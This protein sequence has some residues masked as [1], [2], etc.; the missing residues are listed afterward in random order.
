MRPEKRPGS[1][2]RIGDVIDAFIR[3]TEREAVGPTQRVKEAWNQ[4]TTQKKIKNTRVSFFKEGNASIEVKSP[5]L[6]AELSQFRR[7]ELLESMQRLLNDDPV[8]KELRFR[9]GAW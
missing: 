2:S 8:V 9:L 4:L 5:P 7:R 3:E 1:L 6:C